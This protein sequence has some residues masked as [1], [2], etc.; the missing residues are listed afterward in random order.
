VIVNFSA[1]LE[2]VAITERWQGEVWNR[3]KDGAVYPEWVTIS[4]VKDDRE[5]ISNYIAIFTD[6]S[7]RK[8]SERRCS[9]ATH[10]H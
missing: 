7:L 1:R 5:N 10:D 8:E 6:I 3:R 2:F 9:S 4:T